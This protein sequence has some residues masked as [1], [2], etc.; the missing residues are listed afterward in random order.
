MKSNELAKTVIEHLN[1][2]NWKIREEMLNLLIIH[3]LKYEKQ[4]FDYQLIVPI[5]AKLCN[6]D[7]SKIRFVA[8]EALTIL[9]TKGDK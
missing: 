2:E 4:D 6:N 7:N 9:A 8:K 3:M 5:L 1:S